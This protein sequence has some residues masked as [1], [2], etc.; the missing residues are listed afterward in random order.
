MAYFGNS[1]W[2]RASTVRAMIIEIPCTLEESMLSRMPLALDREP[3]VNVLTL[4]K[5]IKEPSPECTPLSGVQERAGVA[6]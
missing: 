3:P 6:N 2:F 5:E 1:P 4:L